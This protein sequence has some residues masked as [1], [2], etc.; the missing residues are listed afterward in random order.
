MKTLSVIIDYALE[1]ACKKAI[2]RRAKLY[3]IID[4]ATREIYTDGRFDKTAFRTAG[5]VA[6]RNCG[7]TV[8]QTIDAVEYMLKCA[9]NA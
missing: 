8:A 7:Y 9:G 2:S 1:L 4:A 3:Q 5:Q 6:A